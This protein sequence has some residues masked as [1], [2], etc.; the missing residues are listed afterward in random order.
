MVSKK[1]TIELTETQLHNI[2]SIL[3]MGGYEHQNADLVRATLPKEL[4]SEGSMALPKEIDVDYLI[5]KGSVGDRGRYG[6]SAFL[7][8]FEK[9]AKKHPAVAKEYIGKLFL[10]AKKRGF[11]FTA[12]F[13]KS[14]ASIGLKHNILP[15]SGKIYYVRTFSS[16]GTNEQ[17]VMSNLKS[18]NLPDSAWD[19]LAKSKR[20]NVASYIIQHG[21]ENVL[22][23]VIGNIPKVTRAYGGLYDYATKKNYTTGYLEYLFEHR[24][25][26]INGKAKKWD[27]IRPHNWVIKQK[28]IK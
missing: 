23:I 18:G 20:Y 6:S 27:P 3:T 14:I 4:Q 13:R 2:N 8:M 5:V 25:A 22:P 19:I 12:D 1:I 9:V 11:G 17:W 24:V 16:S 15:D 10:P 7:K 28:K 26:I 21:P